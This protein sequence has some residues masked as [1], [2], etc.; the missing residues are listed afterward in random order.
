LLGTQV[1]YFTG[2]QESVK[3]AL[4]WVDYPRNSSGRKKASDLFE[5][6]GRG[7]KKA[8]YPTA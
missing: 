1:K 5:N 7:A 2:V 3:I 6:C 4:K 8:D